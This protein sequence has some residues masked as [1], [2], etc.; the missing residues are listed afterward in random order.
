MACRIAP[1]LWIFTSATRGTAS[2]P[3]PFERLPGWAGS[4]RYPEIG[5]A[6]GVVLRI[7]EFPELMLPALEHS[8]ANGGFVERFEI[9]KRNNNT[10]ERSEI[11]KHEERNDHDEAAD[12]LAAIRRLTPEQRSALLQA[13]AETD[14]QAVT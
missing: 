2:L 13:L 12:I 3:S 14:P 4:R 11:I 5:T 9:I 1:S 7:P 8:V 10:V 6:T